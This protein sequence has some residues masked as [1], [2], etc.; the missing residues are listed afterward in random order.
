ML[1]LLLLLRLAVLLLLRR[2][3]LAICVAKGD[4]RHNQTKGV[5]ALWQAYLASA[6]EPRDRTYTVALSTMR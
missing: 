6:I 4:A 3:R 2:L 5:A 1:P